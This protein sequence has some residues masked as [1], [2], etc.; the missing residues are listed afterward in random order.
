MKQILNQNSNTIELNKFV[1]YFHNGC[2]PESKFK[3]GIEFEKIGV[4]KNT[5]K[6]ADYSGNNGIKELIKAYKKPDWDYIKEDENILG[7]IKGAETITLEPG[8]QIELGSAPG[9]TLNELN[10]KIIKYNKE[11]A[12]L[13]ENFGIIW[14]G[15]GIQPLS[16]HETIELL[17][18]KRY[19]I[20]T[21]YLPTKAKHPLV[22]M[23]ETAGIQ[24]S[25][26][27]SSEEDAMK[28]YRCALMLAPF[29]TA[30]FANSPVRGGKNTG[31]KSFRAYSWL[32]TDNDRCG[33]VSEKAISKD[34]SFE[35]Y[36]NITLDLPMIF[37]QDGNHWHNA[38]GMT[39][40]K[41]ATD[42]FNG[43][44]ADYN[45]WLIHS[46]SFFPDI[47]LKNYIEI[48]S[49]DV[50]R[51]DMIMAVPAFWKGILYN[52]S[53]IEKVHTIIG[54]VNWQELN[55]L[56]DTVPKKGLDAEIGNKKLADITLE[57]ALLASE[58]LKSM[59]EN[60]S[61]LEPL[62][63]NLKQKLTPADIILKY[64]DNDVRKLAQFTQLV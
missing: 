53:A 36:L 25:I 42:G 41:F 21:E 50:Q 60:T 5:I 59:N 8:S 56:R 64:W 48:R 38:N 9:K 11:T 1:E 62:I 12:E 27:Y 19:H 49:C 7:L 54:N 47:R 43:V 31:Y 33:L 46:T 24:V 58:S 32:H 17:P 61:Y 39:F 30:M 40:R 37:L 13:A 35:D 14:L 34:F 57:L 44:Q 29:T 4:Y 6:A 2:K 10:E 52:N 26:D 3:T 55:Q 22:M 20:M 18:K 63:H 15:Y 23:R 45:N 51:S 28:K 16:T